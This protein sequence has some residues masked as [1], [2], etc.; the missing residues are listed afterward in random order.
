MT[1][2]R[3]EGGKCVSKIY[4]NHS[5]KSKLKDYEGSFSSCAPI[6]SREGEVPPVFQ[7]GGRPPDFPGG[8]P[9]FLPPKKNGSWKMFNIDKK[10]VQY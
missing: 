1:S 10:E 2:W 5:W 7:G 3:V 8:R 6:F 9:S 4:L